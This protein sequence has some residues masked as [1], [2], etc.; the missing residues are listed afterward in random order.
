MKEKRYRVGFYYEEKGYATIRATSQK[1]AEDKMQE[2]LSNSGMDE[3]EN[4]SCN[5]REF[6]TTGSYEEM[7]GN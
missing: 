3:L 5:D 7:L 6:D 1:E 4:Y 2:I